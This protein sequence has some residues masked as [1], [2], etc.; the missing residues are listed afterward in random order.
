M[1]WKTT[2][3]DSTGSTNADLA[4]AARNG[5]PEGTVLCARNQTAGRGRQ[6]RT[7]V[8]GKG[9]GLY[10]SLLLRPA[11]EPLVAATLPLAV[12]LA[13]AE[14]IEP[15]VG[16]RVAVKWPNDI[17]V[18]G[19]K[20]CGILCEMEADGGG[21]RHVIAGIGLNVNLDVAR[22]PADVAPVATSMRAVAGRVFDER[23]VLRAV[24]AS[25]DKV[26]TAWLDGGLEAV[27][28]RLR[29]RDALLGRRVSMGLSGKPV[30]GVAAG[31]ASSGALLLRKS[32]G[33]VEEVFSGEAHID[34]SA[35]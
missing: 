8:S 7:W 10:F 30:E 9:D 11:V 17:L 5:A 34:S 22:L 1:D 27:L 16:N 35:G 21:V 24:L 33:A 6:G 32:D 23:D 29:E 28:P 19:R 3:V 25:L 26:Y 4:R 2:T 31:I 20:I 12:G 14:A 18:G 15:F 13:V